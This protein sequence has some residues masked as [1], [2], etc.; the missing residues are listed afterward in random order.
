MY[1]GHRGTIWNR[2]AHEKHSKY[3]IASNDIISYF[4][5]MM[6]ITNGVLHTELKQV[7]SKS[8]YAPLLKWRQ[9]TVPQKMLLCYNLS[10]LL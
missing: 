10:S 2:H 6:C 3:D 4:T 8:A 5:P 7:L 1:R 9:I